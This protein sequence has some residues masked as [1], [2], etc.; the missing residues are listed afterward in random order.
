MILTWFLTRTHTPL[1]Y[2]ALAIGSAKV[3]L[4]S[5]RPLCN[6]LDICERVLL[7]FFLQD[8]LELDERWFYSL[9][10]MEEHGPV[11]LVWSVLF[12]LSYQILERDASNEHLVSLEIETCYIS[13]THRNALDQSEV[14]ELQQ[15][16]LLCLN[17]AIGINA[18]DTAVAMIRALDEHP[19]LEYGALLARLMYKVR[20]FFISHS[21][22]FRVLSP[23]VQELLLGICVSNIYN[24]ISNLDMIHERRLLP[25]YLAL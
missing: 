4:H 19:M 25:F 12:C 24:V 16:L 7:C 3:P 22:R 18:L 5:T 10:R 1:Q 11:F 2:P 17:M 21:P 20:K 9:G 13:L 23:H 8:Q 14:A 6:P 15:R